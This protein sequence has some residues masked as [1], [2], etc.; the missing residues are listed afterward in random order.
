M[1]IRSGKTAGAQ[2]QAGLS[3]A[4]TWPSQ[5]PEPAGYVLMSVLRQKESNFVRKEHL[6]NNRLP[7]SSDFARCTRQ[8]RIRLLDSSC[9]CT[10]CWRCTKASQSWLCKWYSLSQPSHVHII[11]LCSI[12]GLLRHCLWGLFSVSWKE[13]MKLNDLGKCV[14]GEGG[15]CQVVVPAAKS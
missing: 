14:V 4:P 12:E 9:L 8:W 2:Q 7:G 1:W 10:H 6:L 3:A 13:G 15:S 5:T 11:L